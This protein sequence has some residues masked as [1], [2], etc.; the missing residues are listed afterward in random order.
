MDGRNIESQKD[1]GDYDTN[2]ASPDFDDE[3][4]TL[5]ETAAAEAF[6]EH[7]GAL[8]VGIDH[9]YGKVEDVREQHAKEL[10]RDKKNDEAKAEAAAAKAP[11]EAAPEALAKEQWMVAT[12]GLA[13]EVDGLQLHLSASNSTGYA[14]VHEQKERG[15]FVARVCHD[16]GNHYLGVY[17]TAVKAAVA[18]ARYALETGIEHPQDAW[19]SE[20]VVREAEGLRLH[21]SSSRGARV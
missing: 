15:R 18:Y 16:G 11:L 2:L 19:R 10:Q 20:R 4:Q 13:T 7:M 6:P 5:T 14:G 21:L 17:A 9:G 8:S 1:F 3:F 12:K